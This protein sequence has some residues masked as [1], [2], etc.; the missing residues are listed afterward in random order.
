MLEGF[1]CVQR[2]R[3]SFG[4]V[5]MMQHVN[6][7]VYFRWAETIRV[8]YMHGVLE[9]EIGGENGL[10]LAKIENTYES[11]IRFR[12]HVAIGTRVARIGTKS[13]D[14][15]FE[16]WSEDRER[17]CAH[18]RATVVVFNYV[19]DRSIAVPER[20]RAKIAAYEVTRPAG[21]D[22]SS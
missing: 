21:I 22:A 18:G 13:I 7:V 11:P 2:F 12:E 14:F 9:E 5:D 17:R 16:A 4:E 10:I 20:W 8:E 3:V 1:R 19:A 6:N 15:D